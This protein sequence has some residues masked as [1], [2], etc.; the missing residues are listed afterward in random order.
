M[1]ITAIKINNFI[2]IDEFNYN[3]TTNT[4]TL[5]AGIPTDVGFDPKPGFLKLVDLNGD[6]VINPLDRTVIGNGIPDFIG[7]LTILSPIRDCR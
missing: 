2:G 3:P 7:V 1:K 6:G 5:K 4:Y